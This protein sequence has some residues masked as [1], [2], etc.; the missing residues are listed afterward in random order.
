MSND[1]FE[2]IT[3]DEYICQLKNKIENIILKTSEKTNI[4]AYKI[5]IKKGLIEENEK[6]KKFFKEKISKEL[7]KALKKEL[8]TVLNL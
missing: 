1:F 8:I 4:V 6:T 3:E 2:E 5:L 7:T